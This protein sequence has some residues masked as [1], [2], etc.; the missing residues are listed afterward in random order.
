MSLVTKDL[1]EGTADTRKEMYLCR[2]SDLG[3][4]TARL[5]CNRWNYVS[6]K[7]PSDWIEAWF[8]RTQTRVDSTSK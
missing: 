6:S 5:T 7:P 2:V 1:A 4:V 8:T 3:L